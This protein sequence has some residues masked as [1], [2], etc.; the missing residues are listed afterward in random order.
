MKSWD[1]PGDEA[2]LSWCTCLYLQSQEI[3]IPQDNDPGYETATCTTCTGLSSAE[4]SQ[5]HFYP[6]SPTQTVNPA[7]FQM[8]RKAKAHTTFV[9]SGEHLSQP[10][11]DEHQTTDTWPPIQDPGYTYYSDCLAQ[12]TSQGQGE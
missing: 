11:F 5:D 9:D 10:T 2:I 7:P 3:D 12:D 6:S 4:F 1:G 8:A